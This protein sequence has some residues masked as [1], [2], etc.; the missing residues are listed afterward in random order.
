MS[1]FEHIYNLAKAHHEQSLQIPPLDTTQEEQALSLYLLK[2]GVVIDCITDLTLT[3]AGK[4]AMKGNMPAALWLWK[5]FNANLGL[6]YYGAILGNQFQSIQEA[7]DSLCALENNALYRPSIILAF[8]QMGQEEEIS[9]YFPKT[10]SNHALDELKAA[11][12]GAAYGNHP[13]ILTYLL[14]LPHKQL[15]TLPVAIQAAACGGHIQLV[16]QLLNPLKSGAQEDFLMRLYQQA[17]SGFI[18]GDQTELLQ[19]ALKSWGKTELGK[20][21][22]FAAVECS[23]YSLAFELAQQQ[24]CVTEFYIALGKEGIEQLQETFLNAETPIAYLWLTLAQKI[25]DPEQFIQ[26]LSFARNADTLTKICDCIR[27]TA[28]AKVTLPKIVAQL[29]RIET[30]TQAIVQ[31]KSHF[32]L[33]TKQALFIHRYQNPLM[34]LLQCDYS[35]KEGFIQYIKGSPKIINPFNSWQLADLFEKVQENKPR[36][37]L[38]AELEV[39]LKKHNGLRL[40]F[41]SSSHYERCQS[42]LK[43]VLKEQTKEHLNVL[44]IH[45][46]KLFKDGDAGKKIATKAHEKPVKNKEIRDEYYLSLEKFVNQLTKEEKEFALNEN[47]EY[48][49][50][51]QYSK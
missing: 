5:N 21:S 24:N 31:L 4:L 22:V 7:W 6:I 27:T 11:I 38:I 3:P 46:Y 32:L 39:Y 17:I 30:E 41:L 12:I 15:L 13:K 29:E 49:E 9:A 34:L 2:D 20:S 23:R 18:K 50:G 35:G 1:S 28:Q 43:Q 48:Q 47:T 16:H 51:I 33:E 25:D 42:F 40:N 10:N 37:N 14:D 45:Q 36:N 8:A 26:W 44:V 19:Q